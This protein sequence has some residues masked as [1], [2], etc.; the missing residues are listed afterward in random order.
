MV[1][2]PV[3]VLKAGLVGNHAEAR[4][5]VVALE[6]VALGFVALELALVPE[7]VVVLELVVE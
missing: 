6:L 1:L 2:E 7:P 4:K 5:L 3:L